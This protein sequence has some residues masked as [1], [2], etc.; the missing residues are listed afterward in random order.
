M[1]SSSRHETDTDILRGA[2]RNFPWGGVQFPIDF[3]HP[4]IMM[5][6]NFEKIPTSYTKPEPPH[7]Q[8]D[9]KSV[10]VSHGLMHVQTCIKSKEGCVVYK[11]MFPIPNSDSKGLSL[12]TN[13]RFVGSGA[14]IFPGFYQTQIPGSLDV[15]YHN[16]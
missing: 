9:A 10:L 1:S 16:P 8:L 14:S 4:K 2:I 5:V 6:E 12:F 7:D 13:T 15:G 11:V 3:S